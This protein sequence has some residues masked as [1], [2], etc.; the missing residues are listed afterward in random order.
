MYSHDKSLL[1]LDHI[2]IGN[3][4]FLYIASL[5]ILG[6]VFYISTIYKNWNIDRGNKILSILVI[7]LLLQG[8]PLLIY[9]LYI[10]LPFFIHEKEQ[11]LKYLIPSKNGNRKTKY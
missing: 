1:L 4:F 6:L 2:G 8:E 9:P 5:G 7:V 11:K 10:G 3:G